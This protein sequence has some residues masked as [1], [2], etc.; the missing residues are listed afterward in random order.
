MLLLNGDG[1][2]VKLSENRLKNAYIC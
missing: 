2:N 1:L